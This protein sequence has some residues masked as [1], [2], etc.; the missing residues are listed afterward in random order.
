MENITLELDYSFYKNNSGENSS[1]HEKRTSQGIRKTFMFTTMNGI[2]HFHQ[3]KNIKTQKKKKAL[4]RTDWLAKSNAP[5]GIFFLI[6]PEW[7]M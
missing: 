6:S 7:Y 3:M 2:L 4:Q 5:N 1:N